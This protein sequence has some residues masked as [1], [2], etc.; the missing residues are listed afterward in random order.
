MVTFSE[1]QDAFFSVNSDEY[2]MNTAILCKLEMEAAGSQKKSLNQPMQ[3][4]R[5]PRT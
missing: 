1:I 3:T 2:C 4:P 5:F